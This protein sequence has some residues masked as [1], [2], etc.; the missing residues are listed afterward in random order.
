MGVREA[1][2]KNGMN[3]I[4]DKKKNEM[5]EHITRKRGL[6]DSITQGKGSGKQSRAM[7]LTSRTSEIKLAAGGTMAGAVHL[8]NSKEEWRS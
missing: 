1:S 6:E 8:T 4:N 7:I 2:S 5:F 3:N